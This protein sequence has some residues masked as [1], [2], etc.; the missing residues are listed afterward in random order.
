MRSN[1]LR[2]LVRIDVDQ[3]KIDALRLELLAELPDL[4]R[5]PIRDRAIGPDKDDDVDAA[6]ANL[7][8]VYG[9]VVEIEQANGGGGSRNKGLL[10][11]TRR[12]A[13][14]ARAARRR[15]LPNYNKQLHSPPYRCSSFR[16]SW[17]IFNP[18]LR[19][20]PARPLG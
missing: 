18:G 19:C 7:L 6:F 16:G 2:F 5:H 11:C 17:H 10:P 9:F 20:L 13:I 14:K 1:R 3:M 15:E 12:V 4:R 8:Q